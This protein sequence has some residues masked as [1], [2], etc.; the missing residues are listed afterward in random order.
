MDKI[1]WGLIIFLL[2]GLTIEYESRGCIE[3]KM[4]NQIYELQNIYNLYSSEELF[5]RI[6]IAMIMPSCFINGKTH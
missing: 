3:Y 4:Q 6:K 5:E 2:L 1:L